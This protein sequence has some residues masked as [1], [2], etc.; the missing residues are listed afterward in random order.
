MTL[1]LY[2]EKCLDLA[3]YFY[4]DMSEGKLAELAALIQ[5]TVEDFAPPDTEEEPTNDR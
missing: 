4:P 5:V 3:R 1:T 2:D